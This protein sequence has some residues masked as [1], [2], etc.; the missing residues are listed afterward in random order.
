MSSPFDGQPQPAALELIASLPQTQAPGGRNRYGR[1]TLHRTGMFAG[2]ASTAPVFQDKGNSLLVPFNST[3]VYG[4]IRAGL[5]ADQAGPVPFPGQTHMPVNDRRTHFGPHLFR[6]WKAADCSGGTNLTAGCTLC[7]ARTAP[8]HCYW[9][10]KT[11][12]TLL[13]SLRLQHIGGANPHAG[14]ATHAQV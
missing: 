4:S 5:I 13:G 7:P 10:K 6:D 12:H 8:G 3:Q 9:G 2:P 1:P 11:L 14:P